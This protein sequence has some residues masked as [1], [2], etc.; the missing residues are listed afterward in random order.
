MS[1][2]PDYGIIYDVKHSLDIAISTLAVLSI[3]M[4][5]MELLPEQINN[6][7]T[8]VRETLVGLE[9]HIDDVYV[10]K[11]NAQE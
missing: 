7:T 5:K 8:G 10:K 11:E 3:A 2:E 9:E 6:V 1:T 4:S